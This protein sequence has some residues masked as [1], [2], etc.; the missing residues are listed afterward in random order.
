MIR[1]LLSLFFS[2]LFSVYS[3]SNT[4]YITR[5]FTTLDG[6]SQNDV[7][8]IYQDSKGFIW[9]ATNDG[10]NRFDGY[11]FK[12]YGYQSKGLASNLILCIDEDS[13]GNLWIGTADRGVFMFNPKNDEFIPIDLSEYNKHKNFTCDRILVDSYDRIWFHTSDDRIYVLK[14]N[15]STKNIECVFSSSNKISYISD[16]IETGGS[17]FVSSENGIYKCNLNSIDLELNHILDIYTATVTVI[18]QSKLL[19]SDLNNHQLYLYD[20]QNNSLK[21]V[22]KGCDIRK[23]IYRNGRLY[24]ATTESVCV[25]SLDVVNARLYNISVMCN[26]SYNYPQ[27]IVLDKSNILW[28]GFFKIGFIGIMRNNK[29]IEHFSGI[30]NNHVSSIKVLNS[31]NI[32]LG[33]EG[34]GLYKFNSVTKEAE[35]LPFSSNKIVYA[36]THSDFDNKMYASVMYDGIYSISTKGDYEKVCSLRNVRTILADG[37][38]LWIGTYNNGLFRY[39]VS[40]KKLINIYL[41]DNSKLKIVRNIHKDYKGNLWI[42]SNYGLKLIKS[43][44]LTIESPVLYS[45]KGLDDL[46]YIVPIC[47]DINHNIWYGTLGRGLKRIVSID[48]SLNTKIET[49]TTAD[50][51]SSNTIKSIVSGVDGTLWISTNKGINSFNI[52]THKVKSY[53][54]YD[55]LQD[56]EFMELSASVLSDGTMIFGGVNGVNM[57]K[58]ND[59][60]VED[61]NSVPSLVDFKIFNRSVETDSVY[62]KYFDNSV[63]FTSD[64]KLP[65]NLNSFSLEFSAL[66]FSNPYKLNYEYK[67]DG[68]DESWIHVTASHRE[69]IYTKLSFG[70]YVFRLRVSNADGIYSSN[71]LSI[72]IVI[73]PPFWMTWYAY[74]FYLILFIIFILKLK[75]Y[76]MSRVQRRNAV[77]IANMEKRKTEELLE[78]ETAFFTNI[79]HE[80]RTPL[81][82]IHSP[83]SMIIDSGK[84][85]DDKFLGGLLQ[86]MEH[87]S[88][89]LLSLVNQLMNFTKSE[90]GM[91]SLNLKYGNFSSFSKNVFHQFMYL[92]KQKDI[93]L[94]YSVSNNDINFLYDPHLMEQIIYNLVSNAIK[95]TPKGGFVSLVINADGNMVNISVVD[96]GSGIPES[97]KTH[98]FERF[99]SKNNNSTEGGTGIGLFLTKKLVEIH[100]GKISFVSEEGKGTVFYVQIPMITEGEM[101]DTVGAE[102]ESVLFEHDN[103]S[104]MSVDSLDD[105]INSSY[106]DVNDNNEQPLVLVVDDNKDICDML[107]MLLSPNYKVKVSY[108]GEMAWNM[109]PD[110]QPDIILTD[111][112]MPGINGLELCEKIKQDVKTSHIPVVL[113]TAKSSYHDYLM[114]YKFQADAY[115]PKPFDNKILKELI[116]SIINNRKRILMHRNVSSIK[117]SE[118]TTTSTDDKFLDKLVKIIEENI[119]DSSFQIED[120]CNGVGVTALVLNKKLKALMGI[121]ANAFV[122]S[123][124]MKRAAELLKTGRYSISEV[125]YDVGFNDLKY[126]RECFKKEFGVLPQQYKEQYMQNNTDIN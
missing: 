26:Y 76:Y 92:A 123:I 63:C 21:S 16:I 82:L 47:E 48:D 113:L 98:L 12:V 70:D 33:T 43:S 23:M 105:V 1:L 62:S 59:F 14:Y 34:S 13:K 72:P 15:Y 18:S 11:E 52:H 77:Y 110:L 101:V 65:Y 88:K 51:L 120:L 60:Y 61:F 112:M 25:S 109:I 124:R 75:E 81:T 111:I 69:A 55:G 6:L 80:L 83:L 93:R 114:G 49:Y 7:Q 27:T 35:L 4:E 99:Y 119:S 38:F 45:I 121:T 19:L 97:L 94:E 17:V 106:D 42:A 8:C 102:H 85:S 40:D 91:L 56:Y 73:N 122:R 86:T 39:D 79:S 31:S 107:Y 115:C 66:D 100:N 30:G 57:F 84:Y 96:S 22:L 116:R 117:L 37:R 108:D 89:F 20:F 5:K 9:L 104:S 50:G 87:N 2:V 95:Y 24:Y 74:L 32:F 29:P 67:L 3:W 28:V 90:K 64:I 126:F 78:K 125:T 58:P 53:D 103:N 36:I 41:Y 54:I 68:V 44:D 46:D 118:V 71:E 10:L